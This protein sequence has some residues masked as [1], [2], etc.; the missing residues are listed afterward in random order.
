M[1]RPALMIGAAILV[2]AVG[3]TGAWLT[4]PPETAQ[5]RLSKAAKA[6]LAEAARKTPT[7]GPATTIALAEAAP[8]PQPT[9]ADF[10]T[11]AKEPGAAPGA[12]VAGAAPGAAIAGAAIDWPAMAIDELRSR[13]NADEI[14][15][16]EELARRLVHGAGVTKDQQAGAGWL[17][18]AAQR[19][20]AQSAFNV[21]VMYERGFVV[22]RDSTK[23]IEWYRKAVD[24]DLPMAKHN[25]ALLLRDGKGAP[26]NGKEAVELL[27]SAARQ[28][29]AASMFSLG[30]IYERGDAGFKDSSIALAWFAIAAEFERQT[31][32]NGESALGKMASQRVQ[33]LQRVLMPGELERAQQF[34]QAEF[35]Q[36]VEALQPPKPALPAPTE[37]AAAPPAALPPAAEPDSDPP[38]WPKAV[39]DQVRVVQQ[40]LVDLKFLRDKPDGVM[41]P[42]TRNAIR[43]F[44]RDVATRETGEPTREVFVA[45]QE[46]ITRRDVANRAAPTKTEAAVDSGK[47]EPA[48]AS[49]DLAAK[50]EATKADAAKAEA[51]KAE[52][53]KTEAAK[54]EAAKVEAAKA[55]AAKAEA[56]KAEAAK[57]EAA[58]AAAAKAEAAKAE[59]A[60][61]EAAKAEAAKVEAVKAE[62]AKAEAAKAEAARAAAAKAEAAK[63]EAA[64]A[65]AAK[66]EAAK[67]EAAKAEAAK[68][69]A[70]KAAAAKAEAAKAEAAKAE[71]AKAEAAKV[72]AAKAQQA[73]I[74]AAKID[75]PKPPLPKIDTAKPTMP[76]VAASPEAA[77]AESAQPA[78]PN[79]AVATITLNTP[80]PPPPPT[81]ADLARLS[82]KADPD[83]WPTTPVD[84]VK[85]VQ[86]LLRDLKFSREAPDG[87]LGPATRTAIRDYERSLG[88]AQTG[89]PSKML[90]ES[91]K[92]M[93]ALTAIK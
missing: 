53:A 80:E 63:A 11:A 78:S 42:M 58:R 18:R 64:K 55:E 34:G 82:V 90:F 77:K 3:A 21:G 13:A 40:A 29:M 92:E 36:I 32:R 62:A 31:G 85:A 15:A 50:A 87:L 81:S 45:L 1:N 68:A 44:Q 47:V 71:A 56:A 73:K 33:V 6:R 4:R 54:A 74:E 65:E 76:V 59:A 41:G 35:K 70:A 7:V 60:K 88:L 5:P 28:G 39:N 37:T 89:E 16:M 24:A 66:A 57:A 8:P 83:A 91:L 23:A 51:A 38:G 67:V 46:A 69:E 25:L 14:P 30:D 12:A 27:R 17:L 75:P 61:A 9:S 52:A 93:R 72:E 48:P 79:P 86:G 19:G 22:E 84:Q 20:S 26:R 2:A 49:G 10:A 43:A